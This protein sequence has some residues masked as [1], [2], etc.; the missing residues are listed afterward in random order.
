M[1]RWNRGTLIAVIVAIAAATGLLNQPR[2]AA[3]VRATAPVIELT[4]S[5]EDMAFEVRSGD[6]AIKIE[7]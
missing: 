4:Y 3:Q 1:K 6:L 7:I 5:L 2:D